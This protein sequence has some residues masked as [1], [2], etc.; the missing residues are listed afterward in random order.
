MAVYNLFEI[1][2]RVTELISD[3]Y[4]YAEISECPP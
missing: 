2:S 1:L 3:G 4:S